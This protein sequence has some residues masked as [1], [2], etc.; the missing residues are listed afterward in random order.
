MY[1][2]NQKTKL[3]KICKVLFPEYKTVSIRNNGNVIFRDRTSAEFKRRWKLS[4]VEL[5]QFQL[6]QKL[7]LFK[8]GNITFMNVVIEDLI[9]CDLNNQDRLEYFYQEL[10]K[11]KFSEVYK[12]LN[13]DTSLNSSH[14]D[15]KIV[16]ELSNTRI[17]DDMVITYLADPKKSERMKVYDYTR[18]IGYDVIACFCLTVIFT[19]FL[20]L[21]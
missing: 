17:L 10:V 14:V 18:L 7:A 1:T 2:K 6:P 8:Y 9:R 5:L 13:V 16:V 3:T 19:L 15:A 20:T 4:L 12:E 21:R 11:I